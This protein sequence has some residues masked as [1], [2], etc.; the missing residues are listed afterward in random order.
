MIIEFIN[1]YPVPHPLPP[2]KLNSSLMVL[3]LL[4]HIWSRSEGYSNLE[5]GYRV[6]TLMHGRN[7]KK[8]KRVM[9]LFVMFESSSKLIFKSPSTMQFLYL[10]WF[11]FKI[12]SSLW[13]KWNYFK[14]PSTMQFLYLTW[15]EFKIE[16][17]LWMNEIIY[18]ILMGL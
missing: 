7:R 16:S 9:K 1:G 8:C 12:E 5:T 15:F 2:K 13:M 11:E 14:S 4:F 6:G 3:H 18:S 17:S 10:T